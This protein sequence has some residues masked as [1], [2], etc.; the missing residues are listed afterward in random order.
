MWLLLVISWCPTVLSSEILDA[1]RHIHFSA[2]CNRIPPNKNIQIGIC[3]CKMYCH[4]YLG[5]D[6]WY[7]RKYFI[8]LTR[9]SASA[10]NTTHWDGNSGRLVRYITVCKESMVRNLRFGIYAHCNIC[11]YETL[12]KPL[13]PNLDT[14]HSVLTY[15]RF[16]F[17]HDSW[18][19]SL[20]QCKLIFLLIFVPIFRSLLYQMILSFR[21]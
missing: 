2:R 10:R 3:Y 14:S 5:N 9:L 6:V 1:I 11:S 19:V 20:V 13:W 21:C 7:L 16:M 18:W 17:L 12:S 4:A 15:F 8:H